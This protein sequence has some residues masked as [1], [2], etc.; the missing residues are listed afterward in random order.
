MVDPVRRILV[1]T[2]YS[3][4][5]I[6]ALNYACTIANKFDAELHILHVIEEPLPSVIPEGVWIDP[7]DVLPGLVHD[8]KLFL[9][10]R[11]KNLRLESKVQVV[12][13][14]TTGYPS[15][16][17]HRYADD[18]H[19][20][21]IVLGTRGN[22]GLSRAVMGSVAEKTVRLAKCPVLTLHYSHEP[23]LDNAT[24]ADQPVVLR[25]ILVA[26]DFSPPANRARDLAMALATKFGAA[27]HMLNVV[28]EPLPIPGPEGMWVRPEDLTPACV[29]TASKALADNVASIEPQSQCLIIREVKVGY[30]IDV[31]QSYAADHKVDLIVLGTQGHRG[32]A[33]LLLGSVAEK[34]VRFASCPVLTTH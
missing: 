2:D 3:A 16:K 33:H 11:T 9:A 31:I 27:V 15:E 21:L 20:D 12:R 4:S 5:A 26:T 8:G 13:A 1:A 22:R 17:I 23:G 25:T 18:H 10:E 19:M 24:L 7:Q 28:T 6:V 32:L 29:E 34:V 14:V 30:P